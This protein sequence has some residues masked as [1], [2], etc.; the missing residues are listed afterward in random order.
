MK[1]F[2]VDFVIDCQADVRSDVCDVVAAL[3][4]DAGFESFTSTPQGICGYVQQ[5]AFNA[6]M[7]DGLLGQL[8]F[9]DTVSVSYQV[10]PADDADWNAPWE[11]EGF[12]PVWVGLRLVVHDGKHLPHP[13]PTDGDGSIQVEIDAKL[14]FGTGNHET[15]RMM[16]N[17][18]LGLSME[19]KTVLDCGTGTG[20]LAIVALKRGAARAAA[21]DIDD[22]SAINAMH[23]AVLNHMD[24]RMAVYQG[25]STVIESLGEQFDVVMA[26]INRN[27]LLADM[28]RMVAALKPGGTLLLSGFY[29]Q[30]ASL[31]CQKGRTLGLEL[32]AEHHEEEWACLELNLVN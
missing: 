14:A 2:E 31:L 15:T 6:A 18:L 27:I 21:Y 32:T 22:W 13:A 26:N 9:G 8:P 24:S 1:Y 23:N 30:D 5:E 7:L 11:K 12:E 4:G 3:A 19:G 28:P 20:I 17:A 10:L 25:D 16:C 29:R